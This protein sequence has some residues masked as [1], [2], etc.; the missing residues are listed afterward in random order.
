MNE[1]MNENE[2]NTQ[3]ESNEVQWIG[4]GPKLKCWKKM[5]DLL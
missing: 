5:H 3:L 2:I 1:Q 4:I